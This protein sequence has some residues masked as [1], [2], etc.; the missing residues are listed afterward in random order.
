M[1]YWHEGTKQLL[2]GDLLISHTVSNP[3]IEPPLMPNN[4]RAK[5][6]LQYNDSLKKVLDLPV[7]VVHSGHGAPILNAHELI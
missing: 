2:G 3:L 7:E 1:A 5:S 6:L 4:P